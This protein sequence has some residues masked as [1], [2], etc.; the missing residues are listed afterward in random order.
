LPT[1]QG[2]VVGHSPVQVGHLQKAAGHLIGVL[3][4]VQSN[5]QV[6]VRTP[7]GQQ[8]LAGVVALAMGVLAGPPR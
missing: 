3:Q 1:A 2:A 5:R 4:V 8:G 7:A 6:K